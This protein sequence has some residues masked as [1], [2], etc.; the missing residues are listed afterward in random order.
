MLDSPESE[1][2]IKHKGGKINKTI[3]NNILL[4]S[5]MSALSSSHQWLSPA[6][7]GKRCRDPH[8]TL[9]RQRVYIR[10]LH[11]I[12]PYPQSSRNPMEEE[13]EDCNSQNRWRSPEE[14]GSVDQLSKIHLSS[15]RLNQQAQGLQGST[16][17]SSHIYY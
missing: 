10:G 2:K 17:G 8:Q 5:Y 7:D 16:P 4:S 6:A 12:K 15:Q 1:D 9:C 11:Q 13:A 14:H 3:P